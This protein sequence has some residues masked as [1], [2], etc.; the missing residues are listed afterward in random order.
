LR[1]FFV[2]NS[3]RL[4][5]A[6]KLLFPIPNRRVSKRL[7]RLSV[8]ALI[9]WGEQDRFVPPVYA[10]HW[11]ALIPRS[12]V[13]CIPEAGHMLPYEQPEALAQ[14]VLGFLS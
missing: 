12:R 13:A 8:E 11:A 6:G 7:Y 10:E 1:D 3:R 2:E 9:V 4:G 14:A 5:T